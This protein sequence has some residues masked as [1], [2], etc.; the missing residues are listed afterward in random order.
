MTGPFVYPASPHQRRHG[1]RGYADY[2]S[3]RPWLRDE[4]AFRCVYCLVREQWGQIPGAFDIDHFL[5]AAH[6]P[7]L[8]TTYENLVYSCAGCNAAKGELTTPDPCR[9]L[10][11]PAV[12]VKV[13]GSI[14]ATTRE[15]R[16]LIRLLGLDSPVYVE[17]RSLWLNVI[18]LA[19]RHDKALFRRLMGFPVDLP[20]LRLLRP[21]G[22]NQ[23]PEGIEAS[24]LCRRERGELPDVY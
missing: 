3:Y 13:D 1:P 7:E 12:Q 14:T 23:R 20:D 18:A 16:R 9:A 15:G 4:F 11:H 2:A 6:H 17:V 19:A 8:S 10:V 22:G 21:P 24:H 5:A